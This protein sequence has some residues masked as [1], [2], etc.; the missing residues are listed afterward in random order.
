MVCGGGG[1]F[2]HF[3]DEWAVRLDARGVLAGTDTELNWLLSGGINWRWGAR[4]P[5]V[6]EVQGGEID[7]DG[8]GL[9][10][11][12]EVELGTDPYDPDTDG[13]GLLDGEEVNIQHTDPLN[14]DTDWDALK[15]GAEVLTYETNPLEPD[16]DLGGVLDGHE[17]IEDQT[18]PLDPSDDLQLYTLNLEFD[19]DK[20][21]IRPQY[22]EELDV[23][24]KVLQRDP[25]ATARVEG[26]A[27]KR[28]TSSREYNIQLSER[29]ARAV[30]DY[31]VDVGGIAP[32]RLTCKGYGF[33]RP[34][35]P[36]DTEENMQKNRR[37][38]IYIRPGTASEEVL[39]E[40]AII[41]EEEVEVPEETVSDAMPVK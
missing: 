3:N 29:R 20:A 16:T 17:V 25:G 40:E 12:F 1:L 35:A 26:H 8:D 34:I 10:D 24:A 30:M 14:P 4:L 39:V 41:L 27:D 2:Y 9:F 23:I 6:Y 13:D 15:D 31:L 28:P 32:D 36:N 5:V 33:E 37:T 19:Y 21:N 38:E 18:D 22:Y 7:S 11:A